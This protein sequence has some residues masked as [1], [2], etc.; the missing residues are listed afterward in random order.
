MS[1]NNPVPTELNYDASTRVLTVEFD[2]GSVFELSAEYLRTHSPSAEV[3]GHGPGS[4]TLQVGKE[5]VKIDKILPVGRYAVS[6]V[7]DDGHDSGI[8]SWDWL[9]RLGVNKDSN[10]KKYLAALQAAN[11]RHK[12]L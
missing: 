1:D 6:I 2:E 4:Y 3:Q 9:Y 8:F 12:D 11:H 10:W 7:F 5:D